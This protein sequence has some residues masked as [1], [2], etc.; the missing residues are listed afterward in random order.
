V[1]VDPSHAAGRRSLVRA[2]CR[3]AVAA[4]ADGLL[5]EMHPRPDQA[6]S[7]G[8]QSVTPDQLARIIAECMKVATAVDRSI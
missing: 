6:L 7:D 3:S 2:L 4:G 8:E 5:I 1:I